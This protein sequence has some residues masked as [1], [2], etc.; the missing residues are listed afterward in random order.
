VATDIE[1]ILSN[2]S[3]SYDFRSK[4]VLHVGAGGG[5][6][7]GYAGET[8]HVWA[9]DSDPEAANLLRERVG[10]EGL[11]ST[12]TV[13][14]GDF[15][16]L[17]FE[18]DVVLFEFCLHEMKDPAAALDRARTIA[19]DVVVIDHS[20]DSPWA[21]YVCETEKA[22]ACWD[23]VNKHGPVSSPSFDATQRFAGYQELHDKVSVI[24]PEGIR[25]IAEYRGATNIEIAMPYRIA[26]I[27]RVTK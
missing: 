10:R 24:G 26:L 5:Q 14:D 19:R 13:V 18:A 3:S 1:K 22:R 17:S 15:Y 8:T 27:E 20:E 12:V 6:L 21:W 16:E 2:L 4:K 7:I 23:A 9:V 11:S 25:R